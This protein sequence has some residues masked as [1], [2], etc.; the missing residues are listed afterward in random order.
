L[1]AGLP[2]DFLKQTCSV[3]VVPPSQPPP[4]VKGALGARVQRGPSGSCHPRH[5]R[6]PAMALERGEV[7]PNP[8]PAIESHPGHSAWARHPPPMVRGASTLGGTRLED[9]ANAVL[10]AANYL[11]SQCNPPT[12]RSV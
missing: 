2:L 4:N 3:W 8:V 7:R 1:E 10:E 6:T 9:A 12:R 11:G 5:K